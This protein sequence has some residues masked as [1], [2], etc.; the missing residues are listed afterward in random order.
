MSDICLLAGL[1]VRLSERKLLLKGKTVPLGARA[2]DLLAVL[3]ERRD[4][5]VT[6]DELLDAVWPGLVVEENNLA[7]HVSA[8]RKALGNDA[9]ATIPGRGYR[10]VLAEEAPFA[11]QIKA[12]PT[13]AARPPR[14]RRATRMLGRE[15]ERRSLLALLHDHALVSVLGPGGVG[16]T[17]MAH[18]VMEA[19]AELHK[20]GVAWVDLG[21][22]EDGSLIPGAI[23]QAMALQVSWGEGDPLEAL[24]A[25]LAPMALLL[26]L[27]NAEHLLQATAA[28]V[29]VLRRRAP[30]LRLLLTSQAPLR[31]PEEQLLRLKPL[32]V[33]GVGTSAAEAAGNEAVALFMNHAKLADRSF[34]LTD[35][36]AADVIDICRRLDGLPLALELAAARVGLL[37]AQGVAKRLDDRFKLLAG[38]EHMA[39]ARRPTLQAAFDWSIALLPEAER[40]LFYSLSVFSGGFSL[41]LAKAA[42]LDDAMD[43][44]G[45]IDLLA[46]L[47]DYSLVQVGSDAS[48]RYALTESARSHA[49]AQGQAKHASLLERHAKAV[50]LFFEPAHDDWLRMTDNDWL[51]RYEPEL[52]NLRA[53]LRWAMAHDPEALVALVGSAAPLWHHLSLDDEARAWHDRSE[54]AVSTSGLSKP[55]LA[56]WWRAAQWA[57]AGVSPARAIDA[58]ERARFLYKDL[59][60]VHGLYA[61]LTGS[62]G[63]STKSDPAA[64]A[65]LAEALALER[66]EWPARERAWGQRAIAEVARSHGRLEESRQARLAEL[67]LR[68]AAGDARGQWLAQWH[69]ANLELDMGHVAQA[70]VLSRELV[71]VWQAKR[72]FAMCCRAMLLLFHA[73]L[74]SGEVDEAAALARQVSDMSHRQDLLWTAADDLAWVAAEQGRPDAAALLMGWSD[75]MHRSLGKKRSST[76]IVARDR[77]RQQIELSLGEEQLRH[78]LE[79]GGFMALRQVADMSS[80]LS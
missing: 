48:P 2:F 29:A 47:V 50:R 31:L 71:H 79:Q 76:A 36:N 18:A 57:W 53:A 20:D 23:A 80:R 14:P 26:V 74:L 45:L 58:A 33:P 9:I 56:R 25:T 17:T 5:V 6:K 69:L 68:V 70:I 39:W 64:E 7:V 46:V 42:L 51:I 73:L 28:C 35:Q 38:G 63:L 19:V 61:Q 65:A 66:R 67:A 78:T 41:E 27:D 3:I 43:E 54:Q 52:D 21:K 13:P 62:A 11:Q 34:G 44:W 12:M 40:Q 8:L 10:L 32:P 15:E 30:E 22:L 16:K 1:E 55:L 49:W 60:D 72:N 24:A 4:R 37:G 59:A 77:A 75:N